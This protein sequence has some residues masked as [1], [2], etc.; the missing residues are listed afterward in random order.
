MF[1]LD[2]FGNRLLIAVVASLHVFINHPLAVGAYPLVVLLEWYGRKTGNLEWDELARRVTFVLFIITTSVGA[3]TGVGIWLTTALIAPFGIGSL[4]RVFFW[5]WFFEWLIFI[6]EVIL[7]MIYYL[8]WKKWSQGN[9]KKLHLAFGAVLAIFSWF[10]MAVIVAILGFMMDVGNWGPDRSLLDAAF[11]PIY[12]PQLLFRTTFAMITGGLFIWFLMF[13]FTR[14]KL[15]FR[16]R[17][18]RFV[19]GWI[20]LWA[21]P[22]IAGAYLYWKAVPESMLPNIPVGLMT[23]RFMHWHEDFAVIMIVLAGLV[24]LISIIAALRPRL[25]PRVILL[26][27]FIFGL[28]L[29]GHFE[30]V[31]EFIRKPYVIADYMYSNGVKV[32][33]LPVFKRD[34]ILEYAAFVKNHRVTSENMV[35]AG[36]DVFML[37]CSR[38]HT[39]SGLNGMTTKFGDLYGDED[40]DRNAM[41]AFIETM[42]TS[43]TYMPPFPGNER[44]AEALVE[45]IKTMQHDH[46]FIFGAHSDWNVKPS[47]PTAGE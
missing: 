38:C 32:S 24:L 2:F 13:F 23:Q 29:L 9:R 42:H 19:S 1:Y 26:V 37:A 11:N 25:I 27:P 40:W 41:L 8:T 6:S 22:F 34:G 4:L 16:R 20:L 36:K 43:R 18:T 35:A 21:V 7:I 33:D 39:T 12:G 3:L 31:R 5:A 10:T 45:Y 46:K 14:R 47:T 17:A 28:Y 30:R 15:D 44:E